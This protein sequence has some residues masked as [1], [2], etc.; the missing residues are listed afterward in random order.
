MT[1][2]KI[3]GCSLFILLSTI[4]YTQQRFEIGT[5][6]GGSCYQGDVLGS[7]VSEISPNIHASANLNAAYFFNNYL[8]LR[9]AVGYGKMSGGDKYAEVAQ[10]RARNLSFVSNV[11][12]TGLRVEFNVT[13]YNPA[14]EKN[15]T[16]YPFIGYHHTFFNPKAEYKGK[17][18]ALQPLG[19]EGQ[20]LSKYP[21]RNPYK[22][23]AG[24][25][26]YGGGMRIAVSPRISLGLEYGAYRIFSDY[27]D[28]VAG[29]YVPYT[30]ILQEKGNQIAAALSNREG[31]LLGSDQIVLKK[32]TDLRGNQKVFDYYFQFGFTLNYHFF[33]PFSDKARNSF[34]K[35]KDTSRCFKF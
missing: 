17:L 14:D 21:D 6:L 34:R 8:G 23:N 4:S 2:K 10:R 30:D 35:R 33:D 25:I 9:F 15:F 18:Y 12:T 28:D 29:T 26:L 27:I 1:T 13:G 3:F 31:E 11:Y 19:T 24:S 7:S 20:G 5:L 32:S 22:L 16:I